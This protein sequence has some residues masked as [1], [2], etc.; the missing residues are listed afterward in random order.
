VQANVEMVRLGEV[1]EMLA[2]EF[3]FVRHIKSSQ[4]TV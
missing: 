1:V 2:Q 3:E 4:S